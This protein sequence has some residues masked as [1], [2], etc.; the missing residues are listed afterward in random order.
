MTNYK[1]FINFIKNV[2]HQKHYCMELYILHQLPKPL[3]LSLARFLNSKP[4]I[5]VFKDPDLQD[6]IINYIEKIVLKYG[7]SILIHDYIKNK[8]YMDC[9]HFI[10]LDNL[11]RMLDILKILDPTTDDP[12]GYMKNLYKKA[13]NQPEYTKVDDFFI[14]NKYDKYITGYFTKQF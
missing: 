7:D 1:N 11:L 3:K 10:E 2:Y 9:F 12:T 8:I 14:L 6:Q 4:P 5:K 13:Q